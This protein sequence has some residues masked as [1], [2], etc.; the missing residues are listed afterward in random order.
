ML[1]ECLIK[2]HGPTHIT[3]AGFDYVF[4]ED[5]N[6]RKICKVMSP[7][8]QRYLLSLKDY[9]EYKPPRKE[10]AAVESTITP[11]ED[12]SE[13]KELLFKKNGKPYRSKAAAYMGSKHHNL[14]DYEVVATK[15]GFALREK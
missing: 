10:S 13:K 12:S 5:K 9:V 4:V 15:G 6:G 8:H 2:R 11:A 3:I 1:I 7:D 14:T